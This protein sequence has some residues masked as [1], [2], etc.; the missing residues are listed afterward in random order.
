[1]GT[2]PVEAVADSGPLIH[3]RET[4]SRTLLELFGAVHLPGAVWGETVGKHRVEA[5]QLQELGNVR[6]HTTDLSAAHAYV[7]AHGYHGLQDGETECLFLCRQLGLTLL[8]TDDLAVRDAA[9]GL[10][11][12]PVGSLGIVIRAYRVGLVSLQ[13]AEQ[14]LLD[15]YAT[16]T[17][18]VTRAVVD[19]AIEELKR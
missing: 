15:L 9:K 7:T 19:R 4:K 3:L 8:L 18:F 2:E 16:S 1:M 13:E 14:V 6:R 17:L 12:T 10:E 11:V 5:T